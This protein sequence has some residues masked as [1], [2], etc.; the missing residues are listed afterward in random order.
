MNIINT[1]SVILGAILGA[2]IRWQISAWLD[3]Y[4]ASF[5]MGTW[6]VNIIGCFIMG[7]VLS[8]PLPEYGKL[9]LATGFLGSLTTF[10]SLI[11]QTTLAT[12]WQSGAI[13]FIAHCLCGALA[14]IFGES[15]AHWF[16]G[17]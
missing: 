2:T 17:R 3:Q 7:L 13:I 11:A 14:F 8:L 10:S 15:L 1:I 6:L 16:W 4:H 12:S 5:P 9:F